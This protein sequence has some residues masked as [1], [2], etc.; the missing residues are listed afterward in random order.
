MGLILGEVDKSKDVGIFIAPV[1]SSSG[2]QQLT[3]VRGEL[4]LRYPNPAA[5]SEAKDFQSRNLAVS[6]PTVVL[7][8]PVPAGTVVL[9][10]FD[11]DVVLEVCH[12]CFPG[13]QKKVFVVEEDD[14]DEESGNESISRP[15][16]SERVNQEEWFLEQKNP[17]TEARKEAL[18]L[19][20]RLRAEAAKAKELAD[21]KAIRD[22]FAYSQVVAS[23]RS[24]VAGILKSRYPDSV[25][26]VL[27][28]RYPST[29]YL[30]CCWYQRETLPQNIV[31]VDLLLHFSIACSQ[32]LPATIAP[33][34]VVPSFSFSPTQYRRVEEPRRRGSKSAP[35]QSGEDGKV[36][37]E[38]MSCDTGNI[39]SKQ[40]R[41]VSISSGAGHDNDDEGCGCDVDHEHKV[42]C[43]HGASNDVAKH[44]ALAVNSDMTALFDHRI[45]TVNSVRNDG[46]KNSMEMLDNMEHRF[47]SGTFV[48]IVPA[49]QQYPDVVVA[50]NQACLV[51]AGLQL[52]DAPS[53]PHPNFRV[54]RVVG[55]HQHYDFVIHLVH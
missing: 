46:G 28:S 21:R 18:L 37:D 12:K 48:D 16:N 55:Q 24:Q 50:A 6:T 11:A 31:P 32:P 34:L 41:R 8:V 13:T 49:S 40:R 5:T 47:A 27:Y 39:S 53:L 26:H 25:D 38:S 44:E 43:L 3:V 52:P 10:H 30:V 7:L 4:Q 22:C 2:L 20:A 15:M 54:L 23:S 42:D 29:H 45:Y 36:E 19:A 1:Q 35:C 33:A 51:S 9:D 17:I 14:E